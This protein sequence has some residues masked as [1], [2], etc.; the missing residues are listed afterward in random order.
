LIAA[1]L[2]LVAGA[3][4]VAVCVQLA[5][6]SGRPDAE[7]LTRLLASAPADY[8]IA[9][10]P[11]ELASRSDLVV[12]GRLARVAAG[13]VF[14]ESADP[15]GQE[16]RLLLVIRVDRALKGEVSGPAYVELPVHGN[17]AAAVVDEAVPDDARVLL[18]LAPAPADGPFIDDRGDRPA[19]A[20]LYVPVTPQGFLLAG[21]GAAFAVLDGVG[22]RGA[23]LA[24]FL[25]AVG[26]FPDDPFVV[27]DETGR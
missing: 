10:T 18:Y 8:P 9:G 1:A 14:G 22:Y 20:P 24:D 4:A 13:R 15:A 12:T 11:G 21:D 26:R 25:P 27:R 6:A 17:V 2:A 3:A 16:H 5:V 7:G 19:G 23:D